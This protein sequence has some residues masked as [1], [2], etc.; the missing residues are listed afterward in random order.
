VGAGAGRTPIDVV[1]TGAGAAP[2]ALRQLAERSTGQLRTGLAPA[3]L[4]AAAAFPA[5][6]AVSAVAPGWFAG[7]SATVTV[8][9]TLAGR[10]LTTSAPVTF[11][12]RPAVT[13]RD[14]GGV[15]PAWLSDVVVAGALGGLAGLLLLVLGVR[16]ARA[17]RAR[18]RRLA[19]IERY[20]TDLPEVVP[21]L[22]VVEEPVDRGEEQAVEAVGVVATVAALA[23]AGVVTARVPAPRKPARIELDGDTVRMPVL[24]SAAAGPA[25]AAVLAR[26]VAG[27]GLTVSPVGWPARVAAPAPRPRRMTVSAMGWPARVEVP[28]PDEDDPP[29]GEDD[30]P[31]QGSGGQNGAPATP[32]AAAPEPPVAV[33]E[34]DPV[35]SAHEPAPDAPEPEPER[36]PDAV[37]PDAVAPAVEPAVV[38]P[39]VVEPAVVGPRRGRSPRSPVGL[40]IGVGVAALAGLALGLVLPWW[41]AALAGIGAGSLLAVLVA[42]AWTNHR[43][44]RF[45]AQLPD[46]VRLV[47]DGLR[48][49]QPL[50]DAVAAAAAQSP[51]PLSTEFTADGASLDGLGAVADRL[52]SPDL[53]AMVKALRLGP[54][55]GADQAKAAEA[56]LDLYRER[57]RLRRHLRAL[58]SGGRSAGWILVAGAIASGGAAFLLRPEDSRPLYAEPLGIALLTFAALLVLIGGLWMDRLAKV[59]V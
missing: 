6:V 51:A 13:A 22:P 10:R 52:A 55:D 34:P 20:G 27:S 21:A 57:L 53:A 46:A 56:A 32:E 54:E 5:S 42:A 38:G 37:G 50:A 47:V 1:Y 17:R 43:R 29:L 8:E 14:S 33:T 58:T 23:V 49:G 15:R 18:Q 45:A 31:D 7:R 30:Q 40:P 35:G 11:P 39:A 9:L 25:A 26:P 3:G 48:A 41:L 2:V 59:E 4:G 19:A 16:W 12:A 44:A 36:A 28:L 24:V